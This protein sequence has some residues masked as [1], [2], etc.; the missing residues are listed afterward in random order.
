MVQVNY[1]SPYVQIGLFLKN[2]LRRNEMRRLNSVVNIFDEVLN[3]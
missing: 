1:M 2:D 3:V